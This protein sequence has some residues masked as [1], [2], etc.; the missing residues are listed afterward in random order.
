VDVEIEA[1]RKLLERIPDDGSNFF[2]RLCPEAAHRAESAIG[3]LFFLISLFLGC[4][5]PDAL[6]SPFRRLLFLPS[7]CFWVLKTRRCSS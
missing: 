6:L 2:D 5:R 3:D 1:T 7:C 4:C